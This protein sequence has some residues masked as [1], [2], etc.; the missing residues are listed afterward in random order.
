MGPSTTIQE[1]VVRRTGS[2]QYCPTRRWKTS[3]FSNRPFWSRV[4]SGSVSLSQRVISHANSSRMSRL[5]R[6]V[7]V[8]FG[9]V[10]QYLR[11]SRKYANSG[12]MSAVISPARRQRSWGEFD[13]KI[14]KPREPVG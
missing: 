13:R 14:R 12:K 1:D 4:I 2:S 7:T 11:T 3:P 8:T 5:S 9:T 10:T 6:P